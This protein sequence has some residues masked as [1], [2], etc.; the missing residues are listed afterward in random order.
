MK[1]NIGLAMTGSFCTIPRALTVVRRLVD[2]GHVVYPILSTNVATMDTR[3]TRA[4]ELKHTLASITGH[5][6]ICSIQDAEPIGPQKLLDVLVVCP[7]TGNTLSKLAHAI[8]DTPVTMAV[9]SHLRNNRPVILAVSTND[10]LSGSAQNIGTLLNR[11]N[12]YIV[13]FRQD[14]ALNKPSSTV[15]DFDLVES[16]I[17]SA[18][19]GKQ[20][21]PMIL[22]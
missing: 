1:Y 13:P 19:D 4:A 3:F 2:A 8:T 16:T 9:K 7:T 10:G 12:V 11:R 5:D 18:M 6:P 20:P 15:S 21:T 17:E 22:G 14:D